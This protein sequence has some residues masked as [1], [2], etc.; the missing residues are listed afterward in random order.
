MASETASFSPL[1][2]VKTPWTEFVFSIGAQACIVGLVVWLRVLHPEIVALPEHTF[3][4]IQL[5]ATPAPVNLHPQPLREIP[6]PVYAAHLETLPNL[7]RLLLPRAQP[8]PS[9]KSEETQA[10]AVKIAQTK[11]DQTPLSPAQPLPKLVA[12]NVL[13]GGSSASPTTARDPARVQTGG[14]GDPNGI[15]ARAN[16][17]KAPNVAA[18]GSFDLPRG[19]A[20]G[21]GTGGNNGVRG[22]VASSG[23]GAGTATGGGTATSSKVVQST[24]FGDAGTAAPANTHPRSGE[25]SSAPVLPAEIL[26]K[27]TPVYTQ[28]ART[29]KIEGEV[30]VEVLLEA[31]GRSHVVRVVRGLG[32]GLDDNA[33]KAVEEIRFKPAIRNGQAAD[34]TVVMHIV[35]HLA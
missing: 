18:S 15:P 16:S 34:S 11:L 21:N 5:V 19:G 30:L 7:S 28:E 8:R 35:F 26:S 25:V 1:P 27:P 13:T 3:R 2:K 20:Y 9:S 23:F 32:H 6:K 14:F 4:S 12:T 31:S 33:V 17:G 10:P 24:G 22:V 29:L